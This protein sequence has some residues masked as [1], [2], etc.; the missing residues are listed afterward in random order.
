MSMKKLLALGLVLLMAVSVFA[1]CAPAAEA[2]AGEE[3]A[4]EEPAGEE[5]AE[6]KMTA[7]LLTSG[8]VN[9][10]GWNTS[11]YDGLLQLESEYGFEISYTENVKQEDQL[12]IIRD[13]ARK[14]Y[15]LVIGHGFEYGDALTAA[16]GEF[17]DVYFAQV[18]G[19][20]GGALP[21]LTSGVFRT[22]ELGYVLG[23]LAAEVTEANKIGFVGAMEIPT[24]VDEVETIKA[25]V[26]KFNPAASVTVAYTGSWTDIA[27]GK[28][29]AKAMISQGVDVMLGI[30][31]AC[32]AGA[33]QAAEEA[34]RHIW[35]VGWSGDMNLL[36]P[37]IVATSGVQ[38]VPMLINDFAAQMMAGE[39]GRAG[40]YGIE[41]GAQPLGTWAADFPEDIKALIVEEHGK[42]IS[43]EYTRNG[44][45]EMLGR[46]PEVNYDK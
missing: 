33:I 38:S 22:G 19:E 45:M 34:D 9:D 1:G 3:P 42:F 25:T 2:P 11:A 31:D 14:G 6:E 43:G 15:D 13:Y 24:L 17:P 29:A 36:S 39:E 40:I 44:I 30:G 26:A 46:T 4:G 20:A 32:D 35:F 16:A 5:P 21:N 10:G 37:T 8:P 41:E 23:R 28:E 7:A 18:G 12:S 27:A